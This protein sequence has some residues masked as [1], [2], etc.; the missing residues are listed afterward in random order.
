[1][2]NP[3]SRLQKNSSWTYPGIERR[4][5]VRHVRNLAAFCQLLTAESNAI[6][7]QGVTRDIST[8]GLGLVVNYRL[9]PGKL[10]AIQLEGVPRRLLARVLHATR[11]ADGGWIA[12]CELISQL[13]EEELCAL[14]QDPS[15]ANT[16]NCP[17]CSSRAVPSGGG[18]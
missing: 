8:G 13:T 6:W 15:A 16:S 14:L 7:W 1:M 2:P 17:S 12:G 9:L 18:R 3:A 5:Q 11:Q 10:L 4:A